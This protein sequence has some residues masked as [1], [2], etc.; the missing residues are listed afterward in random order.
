M[1]SG[2]REGEGL[3]GRRQALLVAADEYQANSL[4]GLR[5]PA[6]DVEALSRVLADPAIGDFDVE[7]VFNRP[8]HEI[9]AAIEELFSD[10]RADDVLLLYFSCHGVKDD[11]GRLFFAAVNTFLNRLASSAVSAAFVAEQIR[12]SLSRKIILIL[13][14]CY[15]GSFTEGLLSRG[16]NRVEIDERLGGSG[17]A[18][19]YSSASLEYAFELDGESEAKEVSAIDPS[20]PGR[21]SVFTG[22]IVNGLSTGEADRDSDGRISV[23][24]LYDFA[25]GKVAETTPKQTPGKFIDVHGELFIAHSPNTIKSPSLPDEVMSAVTHPLS[26]ARRAVV[27]TLR[28]LAM[29]GDDEGKLAYDQL[30]GLFED[31]SRSVAAHARKAVEEIDG[32]GPGPGKSSAGA[33]E[34]PG[35]RRTAA[36]AGWKPPAAEETPGPPGFDRPPAG[37]AA[38]GQPTGIPAGGRRPPRPASAVGPM[39]VG[40]RRVQAG[41]SPGFF[42]A[43]LLPF[44]TSLLLLFSKNRETRFHALQCA[45]ID[46]LTVVYLIPDGIT[47]A[48]YSSARYGSGDAPSDDPVVVAST[49]V[50][51]ILPCVLRLF[52]LVKLARRRRPYIKLLGTLASRLTYRKREASI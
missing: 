51:F 47:G 31:D 2:R 40:P 8:A 30:V 22:A 36:D 3:Q 43:Y 15:S 49:A 48:M 38:S 7:Q 6:H 20:A 28:G 46:A 27:D 25:F 10:K 14:C 11:S 9:T 21:L 16:G 26:S 44:F 19:I 23:D 1:R 18:I 29:L 37:W 13:D 35:G 42:I 17:R 4:S 34:P 32:A 39:G 45:F 41:L 5:S 52:C 33:T 12:L 24:E 50:F